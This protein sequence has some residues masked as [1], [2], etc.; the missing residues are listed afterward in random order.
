MIKPDGP[1]NNFRHTSVNSSSRARFGGR[2]ELAGRIENLEKLTD[3]GFVSYSRCND[4]LLST[5]QARSCRARISKA[6]K[7][8]ENKF[9]AIDYVSR[10][11]DSLS[12]RVGG[13]L[14]ART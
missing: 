11:L 4:D 13:L 5:H 6:K 12:P 8:A 10:S 3:E 1:S 7:I 9:D 14:R 2:Y